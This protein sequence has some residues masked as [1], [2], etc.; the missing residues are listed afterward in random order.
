MKSHSHLP[1]VCA[2]L[3]FLLP[4]LVIAE[5]PL[6]EYLLSPTTPFIKDSVDLGSYLKNV[7]RLGLGLAVTFSILMLVVNGIRYMVS[8]IV[9]EKGAATKGMWAAVIGL[10]IVFGSVLI[11]NTINPR[12]TEFALTDSIQRTIDAIKKG[13][14]ARPRPLPSAGCET[15][16]SLPAGTFTIEASCGSSCKVAPGFLP[17]LQGLNSNLDQANINWKITEAWPP[18]RSHDDPCHQNGTCIDA[19]FRGTQATADNIKLFQAAA[20][21]AGLR[22]VYEVTTQEDFDTLRSAGVNPILLNTEASAPH[23]HTE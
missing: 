20:S 21:R 12:L 18:G 13:Q 19:N 4:V 5:T 11:L 23:F 2:A 7:F 10:L 22:A 15:C 9:G 16:V 17:K 6:T 8:D 14:A 1:F 3:V